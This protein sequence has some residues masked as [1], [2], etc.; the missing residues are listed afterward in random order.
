MRSLPYLLGLMLLGP[1]T[2]QTIIIM[3]DVAPVAE[4]Q[5]FPVQEATPAVEVLAPPVPVSTPAP[6]PGLGAWEA[7]RVGSGP[8]SPLPAISQFPE[9]PRDGEQVFVQG[10]LYRWIDGDA[11]WEPVR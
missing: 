3:H 10:R 9:R 8:V 4:V 5:A 6:R 2:A 1:A 7:T 11:R